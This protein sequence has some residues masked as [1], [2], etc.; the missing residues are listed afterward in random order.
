[1]AM[2]QQLAGVHPPNY[3]VVPFVERVSSIAL[4]DDSPRWLIIGSCGW[5]ALAGVGG[6]RLSLGSWREQTGRVPNA[7]FAMLGHW[8]GATGTKEDRPPLALTLF[9]GL[10]IA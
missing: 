5:T 2:F 9:E 3:R 8:R 1:M 4:C 6:G 10:V 7:L